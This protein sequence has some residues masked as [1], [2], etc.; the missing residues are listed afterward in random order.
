MDEVFGDRDG[1]DV[2]DVDGLGLARRLRFLVAEAVDAHGWRRPLSAGV[3]LLRFASALLGVAGL[4]CLLYGPVV[5]G[6]VTDLTALGAALLVAAPVVWLRSRRIDPFTRRAQRLRDE[7]DR[8]TGGLASK[9]TPAAEDLPYTVAQGRRGLLGRYVARHGAPPEWYTDDGPEEGLADRFAEVSTMFVDASARKAKRAS[10]TLPR[11][12]ST[13]RRSTSGWGG[14]NH[15]G[16][17]GFG[18]DG[19]GVGGGD[20][21]GGGGSW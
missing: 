18:G 1:A 16:F 21:G 9:K 2:D 15:G 17:G 12:T 13:A 10:G 20:G 19:G 3:P 4:L 14:S 6:A 11:T 5:E 7:A 8:Y